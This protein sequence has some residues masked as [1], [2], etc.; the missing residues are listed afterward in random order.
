MA[1]FNNIIPLL[2]VA[3]YMHKAKQS[4]RTAAAAVA[5]GKTYRIMGTYP[6]KCVRSF[7][8]KYHINYDVRIAVVTN[9][10]REFN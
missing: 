3:L 2:Y 4:Y 7:I 5:T 1:A 6:V 10:A 9:A 8:G